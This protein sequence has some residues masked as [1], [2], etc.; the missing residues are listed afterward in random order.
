[1]KRIIL[2]CSHPYSGS[3]ALCESL[4]KHPK[5]QFFPLARQRPYSHPLSLVD[6]TKHPHK[7][8]NRSALYMDELLF[9]QDLSVTCAY[10][11]CKF[12][13]VIR[14]PE[15]VLGF[16]MGSE[17]KKVG[18]AVRQYTFRLRRLCEMARRSGGVLLTWDSLTSGNVGILQDYL[19]LR[20][21]FSP[22]LLIPYERVFNVSPGRE[23]LSWA[24]DAY[25]RY[26]Y[27]LKNQNLVF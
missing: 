20:V 19:G 15:P 4:G 21:E 26:L 13:Y 2:V 7:L 23:A 25:E 1:M 27:Y 3:S 18:F 14:Q 17:R 22:E 8:L 5:I 12:I 10:K 11:E 16:L 6:L 9:N 24:N